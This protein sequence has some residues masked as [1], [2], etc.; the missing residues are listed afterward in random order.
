M[1]T[2]ALSFEAFRIRYLGCFL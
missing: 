1:G 2:L